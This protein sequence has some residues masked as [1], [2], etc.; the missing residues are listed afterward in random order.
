MTPVNLCNKNTNAS[1][2]R[3]VVIEPICT[4]YALPSLKLTSQS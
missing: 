1:H 4:N 3:E 2:M